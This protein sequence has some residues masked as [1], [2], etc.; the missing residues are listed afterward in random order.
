MPECVH[1]AITKSEAFAVGIGAGLVHVERGFWRVREFFEQY[2]PS[3]R[4]NLAA[5]D[6][7]A[8]VLRVMRS[9]DIRACISQAAQDRDHA[10]SALEAGGFSFVLRLDF[11]LN[12]FDKL[13]CN[14]AARGLAR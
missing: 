12:R 13:G 9:S 8:D 3:W 14:P 2:L 4:Q 7:P 1:G 5:L 11:V 6:N 10:R